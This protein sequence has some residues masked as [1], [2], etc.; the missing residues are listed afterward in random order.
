MKEFNI[1]LFKISCDI[2]I[3]VLLAILFYY[4]LDYFFNELDNNIKSSISIVFSIFLY[5]LVLLP[6]FL[7]I[8]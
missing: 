4:A 3:Q 2:A 6:F 8:K 1:K 7:R 5:K